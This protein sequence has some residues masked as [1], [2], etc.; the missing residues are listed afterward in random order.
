MPS[1][2][3]CP[4]KGHSVVLSALSGDHD[5]EKVLAQIIRRTYCTVSAA[6]YNSQR[7]LHRLDASIYIIRVLFFMYVRFFA[8]AASSPIREYA[9]KALMNHRQICRL[10]PCRS[11]DI[12][13][14]AVIARGLHLHACILFAF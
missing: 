10:P 11:I 3:K 7:E 2:G 1:L 8:C 14:V 4:L 9:C 12:E 6:N 13:W 5:I